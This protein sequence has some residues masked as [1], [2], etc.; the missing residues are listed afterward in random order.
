M[1]QLASFKMFLTLPVIR[2]LGV[3]LLGK[4]LQPLQTLL[5]GD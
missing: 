2:N 4:E 3:D 5:S 1:K